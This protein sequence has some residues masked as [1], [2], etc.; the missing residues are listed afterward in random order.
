MS[1]RLALLTSGRNLEGHAKNKVTQQTI[2]LQNLADR[3][4]WKRGFNSVLRRKLPGTHQASYL[5]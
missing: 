3:L 1:F 5:M 2:I 4:E